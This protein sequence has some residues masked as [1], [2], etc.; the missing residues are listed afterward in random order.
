MNSDGSAK[1]PKTWN[2]LATDAQM[3]KQKTGSAG[4]VLLAKDASGG[5]HF[6]QL[7]WDFG[8]KLEIQKD[9]GKWYSNLGSSEAVA[10]MQYVKN[11]KWKYNA[12][13][14]DPTNEIWATGFQQLGTGG[15]AMYLAAQDAVNQ[16]TQ[17]NGLPVDKL[18]IVPVPAGPG[19]QYSLMGGTPYM[20][21][22]NATPDQITACL[23]F[24]EVMGKAPVTTTDSI[25]GLTDTAKNNAKNGVPVIPGFPAWI[26]KDYLDAQQKVV[27]DN[28][29]VN[30]KLYNDYYSIIKKN[31]NLKLEEPKLT[32]GMYETLTKV[33][34]AVVTDKNADVQALMDGAD[35][36]FQKLLDSGVNK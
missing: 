35:K 1:Y 10:A 15:A 18:S 12:L 31:G 17:V 21:A 6:S 13:T 5:W 19:G 26:N 9:D 25:K 14:D 28:S 3:I 29:N 4:F 30:M 8:A 36:D 32:Q 16:P 24:L 11:L 33:L 2:E 22:A 20:F 27:T 34:Q 23:N 7:A